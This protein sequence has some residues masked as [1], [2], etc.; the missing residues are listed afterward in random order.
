[1]PGK[2]RWLWPT[3][4]PPVLSICILPLSLKCSAPLVCTNQLGCAASCPKDVRFE[5]MKGIS[6]VFRHCDWWLNCEISYVP[7]LQSAG[8]VFLVFDPGTPPL[9]HKVWVSYFVTS[10]AGWQMHCCSVCWCCLPETLL[11]FE[12]SLMFL[13][14]MHIKAFTFIQRCYKGLELV[15]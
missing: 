6:D 13:P 15:F 4:I 5:Q 2:L 7:V 11:R 14:C 9:E 12:F 1:M 10:K 3:T 8:G